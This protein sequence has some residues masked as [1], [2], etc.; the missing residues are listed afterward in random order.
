MPHIFCPDQ[1]KRREKFEVKVKLGKDY[2][3][4]DEH[5]HYISV[6]QL[7][8]RET[9]LAE[10]RY[11]AG[12]YGNIPSHVEIDFYIVAPDVS[13]N[14]SAMAVCTKHGLWQSED[15]TIKVI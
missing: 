5:E 7:W 1:V 9:L 8:N 13:M 11:T 4:P 14:L 6:I 15:K 12:V 10:A 3:H 2:P